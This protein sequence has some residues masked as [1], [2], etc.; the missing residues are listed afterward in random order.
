[1]KRKQSARSAAATWFEALKDIDRSL[2][3]ASDAHVI[4]SLC[5][6]REAHMRAMPPGATV[7]GFAKV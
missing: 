7:Y 1:M 6:A 4:V 5:D 3:D 2:K